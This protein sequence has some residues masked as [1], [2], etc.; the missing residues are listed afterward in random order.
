[1]AIIPIAS[2]ASKESELICSYFQGRSRCFACFK[3][4][5][6][7]A[8]TLRR[9]IVVATTSA[10]PVVRASGRP[11]AGHPVPDFAAADQASDLVVRPG[12]AGRLGLD[13]SCIASL[14]QSSTPVGNALGR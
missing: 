9:I 1:M 13:C 5:S 3:I 10:V 2:I 6:R 7:S 12:S 14:S 8:L 4:M 11:A